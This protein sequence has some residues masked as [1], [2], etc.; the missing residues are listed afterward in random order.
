MPDLFA[1]LE[2]K[3][4]HTAA[5]FRIG[6]GHHAVGHRDPA[7]V[8]ERHIDIGCVGGR[9]P[10]HAAIDTALADAFLPEHCA[11]S[12][13]IDGVDHARFLSGHQRAAAVGERHE[14]R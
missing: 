8:G 7:D 9:A 12:I 6:I 5:A 4:E 10:L 11:L 14:N 1:G 2:A 3:R 13:G